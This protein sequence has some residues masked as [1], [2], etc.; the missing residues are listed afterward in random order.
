MTKKNYPAKLIKKYYSQH[1]QT[2]QILLDHSRLVT[3]KALKIGRYLQTQGELLDLRFL[4]EAAILHDIGMIMTNTPE[5]GCHGKGS[6]LQHGLRGKEILEREGLPR[7]A[8]V[9]ERH[10]GVGLTAREIRQE[11]LPLPERDMQPET[12]EEQII[13]Y[14]DLF[15]SKGKKNCGRE[16]SLAKIRDKLK[17]YGKNKVKIFDRWQEKFEPDLS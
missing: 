12:L 9:C 5:L 4:A 17:K 8:R 14:A 7:H 3:R 15:Y 2:W 16:K 1:P 13:C 11:K 6:Y 10:I